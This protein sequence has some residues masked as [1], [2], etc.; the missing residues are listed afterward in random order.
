MKKSEL[1]A[2]QL[3][4][5]STIIETLSAHGWK[6]L[7]FNEQFD[8]GLWSSPEASMEHAGKSLTLRLDLKFDDPR[9]ILY[10]DSSEGK[11]L[12]LVFKCIDK[13][14]P[15]VDALVAMQDSLAPD[16]IKTKS[17]ELL[18]VC[19]EMFKIS[20]SGDKLIP[21]KSKARK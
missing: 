1:S 5:R 19:P 15:L 11:N 8:Q 13:A 20:E 12:G 9:L 21:V 16:N 17:E 6:G 3:A 2:E 7:P 10:I 18:A 4:T 14:K